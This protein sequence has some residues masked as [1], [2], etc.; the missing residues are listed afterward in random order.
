M[1]VPFQTEGATLSSPPFC[2]HT[3]VVDD[4]HYRPMR[5]GKSAQ[6]R[7]AFTHRKTAVT[8]RTVADKTAL[9]SVIYLYELNGNRGL[10]DAAASDDHQFVVLITVAGSVH[11]AVR[12]S[13]FDGYFAGS[14]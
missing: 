7:D 9:R 14:K 10:A 1:N 2:A 8:Y 13:R 6:P 12:L 5:T 11:F 3:V 4:K